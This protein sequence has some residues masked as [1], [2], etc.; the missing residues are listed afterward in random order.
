MAYDSAKHYLATKFAGNSH[1]DKISVVR[2]GM[3]CGAISWTLICE[4][5]AHLVS[6]LEGVTPLT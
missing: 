5:N 1:A 3:F 4:S 6:D 2:G